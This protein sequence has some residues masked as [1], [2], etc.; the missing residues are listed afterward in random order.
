[1]EKEFKDIESRYIINQQKNM[2]MLNSATNS[3]RTQTLGRTI[4][5]ETSKL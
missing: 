3:P 1:M 2:F 5:H 4:Q